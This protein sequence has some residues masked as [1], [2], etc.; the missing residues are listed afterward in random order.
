MC[1]CV[2]VCVHAFC[3]LQVGAPATLG[4]NVVVLVDGAAVVEVACVGVDLKGVWGTSQ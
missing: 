1:V 3:A 4:V 2:C